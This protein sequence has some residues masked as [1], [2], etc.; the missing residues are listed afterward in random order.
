MK[1]IQTPNIS[2][3]YKGASKAGAYISDKILNLD[4]RI[5]DK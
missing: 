5:G 3:D 1:N 4:T 2:S